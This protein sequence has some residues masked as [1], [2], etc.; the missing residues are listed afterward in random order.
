[1]ITPNF[2]NL[3][4]FYLQI[5]V[6][7]CDMHAMGINVGQGHLKSAWM[8]SPKFLYND[9]FLPTPQSECTYMKDVCTMYSVGKTFF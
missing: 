9:Y 3:A 8:N 1:M 5:S 4:D 6:Y 7:V 2:C